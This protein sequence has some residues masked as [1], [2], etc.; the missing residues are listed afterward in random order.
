[1]SSL[2]T[3][4]KPARPSSSTSKLGTIV[5]VCIPPSATLARRSSNANRDINRVYKI[6][7]RPILPH[8]KY[9]HRLY[10]SLLHIHFLQNPAHKLNRCLTRQQMTHDEAGNTVHAARDNIGTFS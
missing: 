9:L 10:P 1:M 2:T 7:S 8:R 4:R 6:G 3:G 5:N